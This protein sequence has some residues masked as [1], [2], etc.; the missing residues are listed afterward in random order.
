MELNSRKLA[1][2]L[3]IVLL[4]YCLN[5][6]IFW[7]NTHTIGLTLQLENNENTPITDV[8]INYIYI[9]IQF[10]SFIYLEKIVR[11]IRLCFF[12]VEIDITIH[13]GEP[14]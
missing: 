13:G 4:Y 8:Q 11:L 7:K 2:K 5:H 6:I 12:K 14:N 10:H 1:K 9:Y 3:F